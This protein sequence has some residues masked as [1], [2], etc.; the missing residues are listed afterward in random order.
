MRVNCRLSAQKVTFNY[1]SNYG[2]LQ[3]AVTKSAF[4]KTETVLV[5]R[6]QPATLVCDMIHVNSGDVCVVHYL[7]QNKLTK[8]ISGN[9]ANVTGEIT[10]PCKH[11]RHHP[12]TI[13]RGKSIRARSSAEQTVGRTSVRVD[14]TKMKMLNHRINTS[15]RYRRTRHLIAMLDL[16]VN[17]FRCNN[18]TDYHQPA[19]RCHCGVC[20]TFSGLRLKLEV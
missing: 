16:S 3:T 19:R 9:S 15:T 7:H 4:V 20:F 11:V 18:D 13:T 2:N 1:E 8:V 10:T 17:C 6:L 12:E 14:D 5:N